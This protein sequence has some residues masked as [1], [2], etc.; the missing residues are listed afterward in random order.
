LWTQPILA[1]LQPRPLASPLPGGRLFRERFACW[2]M[3]GRE[4]QFAQ[5]AAGPAR[6]R[7]PL[8]PEREDS[9]TP[10]IYST[11][12][13]VDTFAAAVEGAIKSGV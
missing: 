2:F 4:N 3:A 11:L 12:Q 6:N 1:H 7:F 10:N 8:R 9:V 5:V 13:E